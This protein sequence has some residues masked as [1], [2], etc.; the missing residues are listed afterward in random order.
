VPN[1]DAASTSREK[2]QRMLGAVRGDAPGRED[3]EMGMPTIEWTV[4]P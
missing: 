2:L 4:L 1:P 3:R